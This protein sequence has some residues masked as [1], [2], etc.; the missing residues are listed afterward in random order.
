MTSKHFGIVVV[1]GAIGAFIYLELSARARRP[2]DRTDTNREI[3]AYFASN[4]TAAPT[5]AAGEPTRVVGRILPI[6]APHNYAGT[7]VDAQLDEDVYRGLDSKERTDE[8]SD[9]GT[10]VVVERGGGAYYVGGVGGKID[11]VATFTVFDVATKQVTGRKQVQLE[12][13]PQEATEKMLADY[14]ERLGGTVA[15]HLHALPRASH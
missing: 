6:V 1:V 15:A 9:A 11:Q 2:V 4:L 14:R 10:I 8:V 3:A 13:P 12:A 7:R 5:T